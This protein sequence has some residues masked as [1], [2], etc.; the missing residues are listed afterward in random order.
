LPNPADFDKTWANAFTTRF[1]N[2]E[3]KQ[4]LYLID[5]HN[6]QNSEPAFQEATAGVVDKFSIRD[7]HIKLP[8][9]VLLHHLNQVAE[10]GHNPLR[11]KEIV[12]RGSWYIDDDLENIE[13][14]PLPQ[15]VGRG[16]MHFR[17]DWQS[18]DPWVDACTD[19][20]Q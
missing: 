3:C 18:L 19:S 2:S 12:R 9:V 16:W 17:N 10:V 14:H 11:Y 15:H 4:F 1:I 6:P 5:I 13:W 8:W 7:R 20:D